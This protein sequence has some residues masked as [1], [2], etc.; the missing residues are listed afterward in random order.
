M[1]YTFQE[2]WLQGA[3]VKLHYTWYDNMTD[4][5][6]WEPYKNAFQDEHDIKFSIVIPFEISFAEKE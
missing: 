6:S 1:S 3:S 5:P 4:F 2:G